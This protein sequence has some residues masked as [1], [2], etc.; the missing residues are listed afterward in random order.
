MSNSYSAKQF[1]EAI[2]GTGGIIAVIAKRVGCDWHTAKKYVTE[3]PTI[4]QAYD[5]EC[6][7]LADLAESILIKSIK[8][9]DTADAKWFLSRIRRDKFA[10]LEK[11]DIT[12]GGEALA[13]RF[14]WEKVANGDD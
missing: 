13:V 6:E 10:T 11:Q 7:V 4:K 2:P 9:G 5:N 3:Y 8:A 14:I 12:S 1:I